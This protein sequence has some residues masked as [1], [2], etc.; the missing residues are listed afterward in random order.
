MK[1]PFLYALAL[2]LAFVASCAG[3]PSRDLGREPPSATE[4]PVPAPGGMP[5][6]AAEP[7][8]E[9]TTEPDAEVRTNAAPE[10]GPPLDED[11]PAPASVGSGE[12]SAVPLRVGV[13]LPLSGRAKRFGQNLERTLRALAASEVQGPVELVV[14]DAEAEDFDALWASVMAAAPVGLVAVT[15]DRERVRRLVDAC[16]GEAPPLV[17]V[18]SPDEAMAAPGRVWRALHGATLVARTQAG[19]LLA[20]GV[21]RVGVVRSEA[22]GSAA[23]A[24]LFAGAFQAGGGHVAFESTHTTEKVDWSAV[25]ARVSAAS[26]DVEALAVLEAPLD[27]AQLLA[28]LA[29]LG[30]WSS[31]ASP[32]PP[33][34]RAV[35]LV[36]PTEWYDAGFVGQSGRYFEGALVPVPFAVETPGGSAL[37]TRL[38]PQGLIPSAF[39][40][41]V[42]E[43]V[44]ALRAAGA[45]G[46][47]PHARL[48]ASRVA[49]FTSGLD[50]SGPDA[51]RQLY[52]LEIARSRFVPAR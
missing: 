34:H 48:A 49:A 10:V 19:A 6:S 52:V 50:F 41:L 46:T 32:L 24:R 17:V 14:L 33:G 1:R 3:A 18:G 5:V 47:N 16:R 23:A 12:T 44:L 13:L 31:G 45:S 21:R 29:R 9:S 7:T 42:W 22:P 28:H 43:S 11:A 37:S 20:R 35:R 40:A 26:T 36:G 51:L 38:R 2:A 15:S 30:L 39:D 8:S 4:T 27:A 25:A